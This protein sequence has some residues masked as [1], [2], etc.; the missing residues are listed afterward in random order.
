MDDLEKFCD[1]VFG[2]LTGYVYSPV[3]RTDSWDSEFFS[4]PAQ[5]QELYDH[6]RTS[7]LDGNVYLA[8]ALFKE[9]K[10]DKASF[11]TSQVVWIEFDGQE[12]IDFQSVPRPDVIVQSSTSTHLHCYWKIDP[13]NID[14]VE[15]INY[16]LTY[17]LGADSSGWDATQILRPP[18]STNWK[19]D[20]P[21]LLAHFEEAFHET[22]DFDAA[23]KREVPVTTLEE[24][25]LINPNKLLM[26][27]PLDKDLIE[28]IKNA[29]PVEGQRS[30]FLMRIA[31][32]M[33][34]VGLN[35]VQI[36]SL[37]Y[38][39]DERIGKFKHR[40]D[41]LLRLTQIADLALHRSSVD[42][43]LVLYTPKDVL[44]HTDDLEWILPGWLHTTG[45]M[46]ITGAPGVG[47]TQAVIN[48]ATNL[49]SG[50]QWLKKGIPSE[51]Q[52]KV[53]FLSLEMDIRELKYI[54][55]LQREQWNE[56]FDWQNFL[57]MDEPASY[58]QYEALIE[59]VKPTIVIIDSM[60]ELVIEEMNTAEARVIMK[61]LKKIR[62][63]YYCSVIVIHHNRKATEGNKKPK[64]LADVYGSYLFA[65]DTETVIALYEDRG[66][67]DLSV[68][69]ARFSTKEVID[70]ERTEHLTFERV[71]VE[72]K[73]GVQ[74][75]NSKLAGNPLIATPTFEI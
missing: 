73:K 39:A 45:M 50:R 21:V 23:P 33:A 26:T 12:K 69:K 63:K 65:K 56:D 34:E 25:E 10:A 70:I 31:Y 2:D 13:S 44:E 58:A 5:K 64:N 55:N 59:Q 60:M 18:T 16:R 29:N 57:I 41:R 30:S 37:L 17:Y 66:K 32:D 14:T 4:W 3:K 40:R 22:S 71:V 7:S 43:Q 6:V 19:H 9:K 48:L 62:R 42:N 67:L 35:Q 72:K 68:L 1:F 27:L 8:P 11:K 28:A 20:L 38:F 36:T 49:M 47:K 54:F 52:E 51:R 75:V 74:D 24:S 46:M 61:W 53:L 15:D